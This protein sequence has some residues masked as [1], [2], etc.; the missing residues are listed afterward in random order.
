[1]PP[2]RTIKKKTR[3][4]A[5]LKLAKS[6]STVFV[7]GNATGDKKLKPL[8]IHTS[9]NP[10]CFRRKVKKD[11]SDLP[12]FWTSNQKAW[13]TAEKFEYWFKNDSLPEVRR[14]CR[15][16]RIEF[17]ILLLLDNCTGQF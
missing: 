10:H 15:M 3:K 7:G 14:Y 12:V 2:T 17:K 8:W 16:K 4:M 5:G 1:M 11:K 6:R 9:Q 13:M